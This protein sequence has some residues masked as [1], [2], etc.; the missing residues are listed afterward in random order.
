ML[1]CV[2]SVKMM[3]Q[4]DN[5][6]RKYASPEEQAIMAKYTGW[7]GLAN[8]FDDTRSEWSDEYMELK[9]LLT[10]EEYV[11]ARS[12]VTD[13]FYTPPY[14][15]HSVYKALENM[16]F[17]SGKILD[18]STGIGNF[19][20]CMPVEMKNRSS[21]T[22]TEVD[23][24]SGRIAQ[25]LYPL[26]NIEITGFEKK[27]LADNSFDVVVSNIPFGDIKINDR[28][29]NKHNFN[30][31]EYFFAKSLDKVRAG[32]IVAFITSTSTMD[33]QNS[34]VRKYISDR[35]ELLGAIRLP[36]NAFKS[37]AGTEVTSDI[38]FLKKLSLS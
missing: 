16:G 23:K 32:G 33:K 4:L 31:H 12:T 11:S 24:I 30:I 26:T 1:S 8:A 25:Y 7:G 36:N 27:N 15:I 28:R 37:Y 18:P 17:M 6:G 9:K 29:Y 21:I 19:I 35:A 34:S 13:A 10:E 5:E 38:I 20:G 14:I 22:A 2:W 3:K